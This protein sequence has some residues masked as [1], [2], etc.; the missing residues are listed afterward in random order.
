LSHCLEEF[1]EACL[2]DLRLAKST[3][4]IH[5]REIRRFLQHCAA[6]EVDRKTIRRYLASSLKEASRRLEAPKP[7]YT[8]A[9][10]SVNAF[11][12]KGL[13]VRGRGFKPHDRYGYPKKYPLLLIFLIH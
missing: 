4:D 3:V 10:F 1:K 6:E 7:S 11:P 8:N 9:S 5:V 2:A 12:K 13:L